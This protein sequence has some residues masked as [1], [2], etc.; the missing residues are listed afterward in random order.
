MREESGR[1]RAESFAESQSLS[2][3]SG[4]SPPGAINALATVA[5]FYSWRT[6]NNPADLGELE[7]E[8]LQRMLRTSMLGRRD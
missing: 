5:E 8:F 2:I 4:R 7:P 3:E 1:R 6:G